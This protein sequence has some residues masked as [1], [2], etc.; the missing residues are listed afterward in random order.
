M[1][2]FFR[3]MLYNFTCSQTDIGFLRIHFPGVAQLLSGCC[4]SLL[5]LTATWCREAAVGLSS[6][7]ANCIF[8]GVA[9]L[10]GRLVWELSD[11]IFPGNEPIKK[12]VAALALFS[13]DF[14]EA[15]V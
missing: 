12:T 15:A 5:L 8:P 11:P 9:Q 7:D 3:D 2:A 14:S 13:L 1:I 10:V 4:R 6:G